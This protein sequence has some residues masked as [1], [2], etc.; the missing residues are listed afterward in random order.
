M[1]NYNYSQLDCVI[2]QYN[3]KIISWVR[4]FRKTVAHIHVR[5]VMYKYVYFLEQKGSHKAIQNSWIHTYTT[6]TALSLTYVHF[7][8]LT[9]FTLLCLVNQDCSK[10]NTF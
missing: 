4:N 6:N 9:K 5:S 1:A 10:Q 8:V 7:V 2:A 3:T